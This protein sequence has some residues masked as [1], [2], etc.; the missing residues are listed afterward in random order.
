MEAALR[1]MQPIGRACAMR[2]LAACMPASAL[3]APAALSPPADG[4][5]ETE[6]RPWHLL[7]D[8]LVEE[9][10]AVAR[11]ATD[12]QLTFNSMAALTACLQ[13]ATGVHQGKGQSEVRCACCACCGNARIGL[14]SGLKPLLLT[15]SARD[16]SS[17]L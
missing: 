9:A 2:A 6:P 11:G 17:L 8:G 3:C 10:L 15:Q 16:A 12:A 7:V 5:T 1:G 4:G 13:R 14:A